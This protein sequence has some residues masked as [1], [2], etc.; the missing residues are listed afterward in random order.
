MPI[1]FKKIADEK[2]LKG[3]RVLVRLD[4]NVPIVGDE[5]RDDFR[6]K[7]SLPTLRMLKER[8]ARTIVISHIE[9]ELTDSLSRVAAYIS[10]SIEIKAFVAKIED[11]PAVMKTME[12][13][14]IIM[15]ENLRKNPGE[16]ENDPV[17]AGRLASL[18]DIYVNDAFAV[19]HREHAS[20]VSVPKLIPAYAGPLLSTEVEE[21]SKAFNPPRPFLFI[22]GG[23]KFDTKL[24]LI[25]KFLQIADYVFV[26]GALS[27]DIYKEKGYE[28]GRSVVAKVRINLKHIEQSPKLIVPSDVMVE[29]PLEKVVKSPDHVGLG[30][31]IMDSGPRTISELADL[32]NEMEFVL[33]NGP[34]GE[35]EKGFGKGTE[36]LARAI[37]ES[38]ARSVIGGGDTIAVVSKLGLLDKFTFAS[39]GGGAMIEFLAKGTL[40]GIDALEAS[41][42]S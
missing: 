15:L 11:A 4:L 24:P 29:N 42:N 19:S 8:G 35:Y 10:K 7:R 33:W 1:Q 38:G 25:E 32:L 34:L 41:Q 13:G 6:I 18:A 23:A 37:A 16:K 21:L 5:V 17:F 22:L 39:T 36:D 2:N 30:D 31:K 14:D 12:D 40:P 28:I 27:N 20:I 26:G 9:N 3:K